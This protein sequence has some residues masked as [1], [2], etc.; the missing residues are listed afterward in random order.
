MQ[1]LYITIFH[2]NF[3]PTNAM[4]I[5]CPTCQKP[6]NWNEQNQFRPFCSHRCKLI[7][8]GDWASETNRIAGKVETSLLDNMSDEELFELLNQ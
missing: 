4:K 2:S 6:T 3:L 5:H 1:A 8:L 7:D